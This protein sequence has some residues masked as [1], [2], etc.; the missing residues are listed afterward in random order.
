M[1][2]IAPKQNAFKLKIAPN[3]EKSIAKKY[4][5]KKMPPHPPANEALCLST[6]R[7]NDKSGTEHVSI[8]E[9]ELETKR[10]SLLSAHRFTIYDLRVPTTTLNFAITLYRKS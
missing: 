6:P 9:K 10:S 8:P 5:G 1:S 2:G 4:F 3:K 7:H